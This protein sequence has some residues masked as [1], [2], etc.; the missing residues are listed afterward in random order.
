[1]QDSGRVNRF[2]SSAVVFIAGLGI[3]LYIIFQILKGSRF[4]PLLVLAGVLIIGVML[5]LGKRY[6]L[7][8][9]IGLTVSIGAIPL[10]PRTIELSELTVPAAFAMFLARTALI[11]KGM[12]LFSKENT[13][14]FLFFVWVAI[15]WFLNPTGLM[16]LGS[17][18]MG[19]RFYLTLLTAFMAFIVLSNEVID[20]RDAQ[21]L[22]RTIMIC[23]IIS[24]VWSICSF[25]ISPEIR[26]MDPDSFYSW[27]QRMAG[28]AL[29]I[30]IW[31]FARK[32]IERVLRFDSPYLLLLLIVFGIA[33]WSGKRAA[34][35]SMLLVPIFQVIIDKRSYSRLLIWGVLGILGLAFLVVGHG[36]V[37]E[38]PRVV[39]RSIANLPGQWDR[40]VYSATRGIFRKEIRE[41]AVDEIKKSP[42]TGM[43]GYAVDRHT[44]YSL[45][46]ARRGG[47]P[48]ESAAFTRNWHNTWLGIAAD[49]GIPATL[50]WFGVMVQALLLARWVYRQEGLSENQRVLTEMF[51]IMLI[52][53]LLRSWTS[54]HSAQTPVKVLW[55]YGVLI[56]MKRTVVS[57]DKIQITRVNS[58]SSGRSGQ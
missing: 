34:L 36:R 17:N 56:G 57:N 29:W 58:D 25:L 44:A 23:V 35:A 12:R 3:A 7:I 22:I 15:V 31:L 10:G 18:M 13:F 27:H 53:T 41:I 50:F 5:V 39:Q 26:N 49:F 46:D 38:L 51:F 30:C 45:L 54:G 20:D 52:I 33:F 2:I 55:M 9:P 43:G 8:V 24:A 4:M 21:I 1:M 19:A 14:V 42:V 40:D 37:F 32:K 28:P 16:L 48:Y 47:G 6:W 11:K